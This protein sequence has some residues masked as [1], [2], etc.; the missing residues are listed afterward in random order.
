MNV[1]KLILKSIAGSL[2]GRTNNLLLR[3]LRDSTETVIYFGGDG[4]VAL[5]SLNGS[6]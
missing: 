3:L 2:P 1:E 4:E 6:I 5:R